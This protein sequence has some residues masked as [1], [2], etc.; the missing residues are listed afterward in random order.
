M[1]HVIIECSSNLRERVDLSA[2]VTRAH[3]AALATGVFPLGG[4]RTRV[5]ER[6]DYRIADGDP[7]NAFA[8]VTVR[9]GHGRDVATKERAAKAIFD[10]ICDTLAPVFAT[11]PL[12]IS[13][14]LQ[15]IDPS[16]SFKH[17]N[18][19]EYVERRRSTATSAR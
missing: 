2:L 13:L 5:A 14:E 9:I 12:A 8:H 4:L 18:L 6:G 11:T 15:E 7:A 17:N 19:H 1:P 3:E 10:A 16:T